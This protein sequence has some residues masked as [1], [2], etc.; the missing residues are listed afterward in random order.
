MLS[1]QIEL[2]EGE[3]GERTLRR[4]C[5]RERAEQ[6]IVQDARRNARAAQPSIITSK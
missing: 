5:V 1:G 2:R 6:R 3:D 4:N